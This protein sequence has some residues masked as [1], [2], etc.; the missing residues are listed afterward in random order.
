MSF[1]DFIFWYFDILIDS[2]QRM[3]YSTLYVFVYVFEFRLRFI[4]IFP[5]YFTSSIW[6]SRI[7]Y[8]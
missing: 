2:R 3:V 4:V 7:I 6:K 1:L 8:L 5:P